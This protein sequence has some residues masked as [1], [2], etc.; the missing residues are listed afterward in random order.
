MS[1]EFRLPHGGQINRQQSLNFSFNGRAL[2]GFEG[3]SLAAALLANGIHHVA[4]SFK[5]HRPRG[6]YSA[7][8]EEPNALLEIGQGARR[9]TNSRATL[10]RL[11]EGLVANSQLG[12]PGLG[13]DLGRCFDFTHRLW[14]AGFYNKTFKWPS[15][16]FWEP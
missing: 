5:F 1:Q 4:R 15:W 16:H 10:V 2:Q 12:W 7:G 11:Q 13:F 9:V 14:P 8:E 6:I 3:D